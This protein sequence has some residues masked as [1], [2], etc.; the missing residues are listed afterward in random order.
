MQCR[1]E[2]FVLN[3]INRFNLVFQD[4]LPSNFME[5]IRTPNSITIKN[6]S[7]SF[8]NSLRSQVHRALESHLRGRCPS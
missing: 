3:R 8:N 4:F 7:N 1:E 2:F 6:P 5:K